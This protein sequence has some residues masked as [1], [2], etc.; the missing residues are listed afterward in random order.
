MNSR[1][2]NCILLT[3]GAIMA[4]GCQAGGKDST[5]TKPTDPTST[6]RPTWLIEYRDEMGIG[7]EMHR[8]VERP[9]TGQLAAALSSFGHAE[10]GISDDAANRLREEG[11]RVIAVPMSEIDAVVTAL[12]QSPI[13]ERT[14]MGRAPR[15]RQIATGAP[16]TGS[17]M[18]RVNGTISP[19]ANGR[20][21]MLMR[22]FEMRMHDPDSPLRVETVLQF[23][24]PV[25]DSLSVQRPSES[26]QGVLVN[27]SSLRLDLD[28]EYAVIL[29]AE[30]VDRDWTAQVIGESNSIETDDSAP[31]DESESDLPEDESSPDDT[32]PERLGGR[33]IGPDGPV[34]RTAGEEALISVD[35]QSRMVLII[36]PRVP[37][38][39]QDRPQTGSIEAVTPN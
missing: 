16:L 10:L 30:K 22:S 8:L 6:M 35:G 5:A 4:V 15:W 14:W 24:Q 3:L 11:L 36:V 33:E 38:S 29:T 7:V 31:P 21:R 2:T 20:F 17:Q 32:G 18:V 9:A 27:R 26:R 37:T 19:F 25:V 39:G 12:V 23:Y 13:V 1:Y 28:G 34:V